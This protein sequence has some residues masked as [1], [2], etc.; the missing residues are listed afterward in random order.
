MTLNLYWGDLH[1]HCSISYGH[2]T[3]QQAIARARQQLDF[4]SVTGHAF[5][6]D[7]P[8]DRS[9]YAEIIDYHNSGFA[10]LAGN[11]DELIAKQRSASVEHEFVVLP[12][13][14]WHSLKYGDHNVYARGPELPLRDAPDLPSL[15]EVA[16]RVSMEA[17]RETI[18]R[19][20]EHTHWNR[21][22]AAR[23]L[24]VSYKTLLQKIRACGLEPC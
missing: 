20:L 9:V 1:S 2:G 8:T 22:Q 14:E 24:N 6:P 5:W 7:M 18:D 19:V 3:L 11:W 16:A 21:K 12:S 17:E 15:R 10:T 23:L 13:Y 4:A